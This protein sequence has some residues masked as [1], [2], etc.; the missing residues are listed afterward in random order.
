MEFQEVAVDAVAPPM[1]QLAL[2][3]EDHREHIQENF[4]PAVQYMVR[5]IQT[6]SFLC[7]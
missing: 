1:F 2:G 5:K 3:G 4:G 7:L 6:F